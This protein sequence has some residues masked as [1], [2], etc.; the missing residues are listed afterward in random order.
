MD[1][2]PSRS[3]AWN[4]LA[5][6]SNSCRISA[7]LFAAVRALGV[8]RRETHASVS[9]ENAKTF[10]I[11]GAPFI[12]RDCTGTDLVGRDYSRAAHRILAD[13]LVRGWGWSIQPHLIPVA[14]L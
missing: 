1:I 13:Y 9:P 6:R 7:S 8:H 2:I 14:P 12:S 5:H 11:V 10:F 4:A 3:L